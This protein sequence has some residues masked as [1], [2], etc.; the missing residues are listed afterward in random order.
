MLPVL[1]DAGAPAPAGGTAR[2]SE[3]RPL[4]AEIG[5]GLLGLLSG[6]ATAGGAVWALNPDLILARTL[7]GFGGVGLPVIIGAVAVPAGGVECSEDRRDEGAGP[8]WGFRRR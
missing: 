1:R 7:V 2:S 3:G 6:V 8:C 4:P 5:L